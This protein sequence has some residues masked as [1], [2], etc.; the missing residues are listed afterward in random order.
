MLVPRASSVYR[1][2]VRLWL[3]CESCRSSW[4]LLMCSR[5]RT[6]RTHLLGVWFGLSIPC[7][8]GLYGGSLPGSCW[9]C[10]C[11]PQVRSRSVR[12]LRQLTTLWARWVTPGCARGRPPLVGRLCFLPCVIPFCLRWHP[13]SPL[14]RLSTRWFWYPSGLPRTT[15]TCFVPPARHA[16]LL[17]CVA[18]MRP[19]WMLPC[20]RPGCSLC[21]VSR[22]LPNRPPVTWVLRCERLLTSV[23]LSACVY[24]ACCLLRYALAGFAY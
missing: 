13:A 16:G 10:T 20:P 7:L 23:C 5:R 22:R 24:P 14:A 9:G 12:C 8:H 1:Y 21:F 4:T 17:P 11:L 18:A 3:S 15:I 2:F 19:L 6:L